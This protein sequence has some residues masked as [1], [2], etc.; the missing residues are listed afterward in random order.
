MKKFQFPWFIWNLWAN[1][2]FLMPKKSWQTFSIKDRRYSTL[3]IFLKLYCNETIKKLYFWRKIAIFDP[4]FEYHTR[5][6]LKV[7]YIHNVSEDLPKL[8]ECRFQ[9]CRIKIRVSPIF[10][11]YRALLKHN[12]WWTMVLIL[13]KS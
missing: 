10:S 5:R 11:I 6:V 7:K 9:P 1:R 13:P 2:G 12:S 3:K 4:L 8:Y